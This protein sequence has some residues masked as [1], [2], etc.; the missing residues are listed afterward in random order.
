[1]IVHEESILEMNSEVGKLLVEVG[2]T[3]GRTPAQMEPIIRKLV[4]EEWFDT[5]ESLRGITKDQWAKLALPARLV[6]SIKARLGSDDTP[7]ALTPIA[8]P[9]SSKRVVDSTSPPLPVEIAPTSLNDTLSIPVAVLI[10]AISAEI[11]TVTSF[12]DS[13]ED[14][15]SKD[16]FIECLQTLA[17]IVAN[18]LPDP[19]NPKYRQLRATNPKFQQHVGRWTSALG[20]LKAAGFE[21]ENDTY[22][23]AIVYISRFTDIQYEIGRALSKLGVEPARTPSAFNPFKSSI[24][25]AGDTFGAPR[26]NVLAE[27]EQEVEALRREAEEKSQ[28]ANFRG[29]PLERPRL[30]R[31]DGA[32]TRSTFLDMSTEDED[33]MILLSSMRSIAA[34]GENAS[35][36]RSREKIQLEKL[37]SRQ[38]FSSTKVRVIFGDKA[39]LELV[40]SPGETVQGLYAIVS[41]CM[42]DVSGEWVLTVSPP[43]RKLE[44]SSLKTMTEEQFVPS[45]VVRMMLNGKLCCSRDV[46][47]RDLL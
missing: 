10:D 21:L 5:L 6:E 47:H 39:A 28:S 15:E 9:E 20:L 41:G 32:P 27:R 8:P 22:K 45:V 26:G 13:A 33:R 46:I 31:L 40:V 19:E 43:A 38:V 7:P 23:C 18:I 4:E 35:K 42:E 37:K 1:M 34:A 3:L 36:F 29:Q 17:K 2:E 44:R 25:N 14:G 24:T 16:A 12:D 11:R 30:V